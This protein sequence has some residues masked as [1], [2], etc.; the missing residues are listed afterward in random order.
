[1]GMTRRLAVWL[2]M[3]L[4]V[5][6]SYASMRMSGKVLAYPLN[7]YRSDFD[8]STPRMPDFNP[9]L[10]IGLDTVVH[11][12]RLYP[13][14]TRH[15]YVYQAQSALRNSINNKNEGTQPSAALTQLVAESA[16]V[17]VGR[18]EPGVSLFDGQYQRR[19]SDIEPIHESRWQRLRS[20]RLIDLIEEP[21]L[22]AMRRL[23][24]MNIV[25]TESS[26]NKTDLTRGS[27]HI[28]NSLENVVMYRKDN[29][30]ALEGPILHVKKDVVLEHP[31]HGHVG[32]TP[33]FYAITFQRQMAEELRRARD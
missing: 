12:Q 25:T 8:I 3:M 20:D 27:R 18:S 10:Q 33:G 30:T 26:A 21:L 16:F 13:P 19:L 23:L 2:I 1:M 5:H 9:G 11:Y 28:L 22:P 24:R 17:D 4:P 6:S 14:R 31:D 29:P 32:L 15:I 7:G